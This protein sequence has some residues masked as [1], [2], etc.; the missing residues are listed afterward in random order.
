MKLVARA[1]GHDDTIDV[2]KYDMLIVGEHSDYGITS[3]GKKFCCFDGED[4]S[5]DLFDTVDE[6]IN[7]LVSKTCACDPGMFDVMTALVEECGLTYFEALQEF[8]NNQ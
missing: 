7:D 4:V 5:T 6:A 3:C 8:V 1:L 2:D